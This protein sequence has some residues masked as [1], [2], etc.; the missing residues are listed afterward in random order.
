MEKTMKDWIKVTFTPSDNDKKV[1]ELIKQ[2]Y[3]THVVKVAGRGTIYVK[4]K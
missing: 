1:V 2:L 3:K 4:K